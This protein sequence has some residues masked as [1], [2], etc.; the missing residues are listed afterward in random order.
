MHAGFDHLI[1]IDH[2]ILAQHGQAHSGANLNEILQAAA[3]ARP[4][5]QDREAGR[6]TGFIFAGNLDRVR[7]RQDVPGGRALALQLADQC[8]LVETGNHGHGLSEAARRAG[9]GQA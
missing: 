7:A 1:G 5:R 3:K 9:L 4:I 6:A 2:E 8:V